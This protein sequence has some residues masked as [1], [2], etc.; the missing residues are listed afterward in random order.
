MI[1][2]V[3]SLARQLGPASTAT[4]TPRMTETDSPPPYEDLQADEVPPPQYDACVLQF[5]PKEEK[6]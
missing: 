6:I 5:K 2:D 1:S 3:G 4:P